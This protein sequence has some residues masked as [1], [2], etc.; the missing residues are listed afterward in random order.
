MNG[1]IFLEIRFTAID[2]KNSS[3]GDGDNKNIPG[4]TREVTMNGV[5]M[6]Y[7]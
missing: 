3:R 2:L 7:L 1:F 5:L 6:A 4:V